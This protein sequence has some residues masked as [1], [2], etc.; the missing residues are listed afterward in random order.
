MSDLRVTDA[1]RRTPRAA[2]SRV[3]W[4]DTEN[5]SA[6]PPWTR[7][8]QRAASLLLGI[9]VFTRIAVL[10]LVVPV[11][12]MIVLLSLTKFFLPHYLANYIFALGLG[13]GVAIYFDVV[14]RWRMTPPELPHSL[15]SPQCSPAAVLR[16][17]DALQLDDLRHLLR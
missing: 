2:S 4:L 3:A 1:E 15:P 13:I 5:A 12:F 10:Y 7:A 8:L 6:S 16:Q 9:C 11:A 14:L 17:H